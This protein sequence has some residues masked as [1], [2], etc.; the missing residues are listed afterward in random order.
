MNLFAP[1]IQFGPY[2]LIP[3]LSV[4][5]FAAWFWSRAGS[6]Y[7]VL[8]RLSRLISKSGFHSK[9]LEAQWQES[10]DVERFRF[11]YHIPAYTLQDVEKLVEWAKSNDLG[12][13]QIGEIR[14][15]ID[16]R[17]P[18]FI[19]PVP[20]GFIGWERVRMVV[21]LA[22]M[23]MALPL[24]NVQSALLI[25][26][27]SR[28]LILA[29]PEGIRPLSP[30]KNWIVNQEVCAAGVAE[31]KLV[32]G[33]TDSEAASLCQLIA[34]KDFSDFVRYTV[35]EQLIGAAVIEFPT[36]LWGFLTQRRLL[37]ATRAKALR[38]RLSK[39]AAASPA[40]AAPEAPP[41][42]EQPAARG[43]QRKKPIPEASGTSDA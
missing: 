16:V 42:A 1:L 41:P 20:K 37:S 7:I 35:R 17:T 12:M 21:C 34:R 14:S 4:L 26:N 5:L 15:W 32:S 43:R 33:F 11:I 24:I 27:H 2:K 10:H 36:I 39:G 28:Q 25:T 3:I 22:A 6:I 13:Q 18:D 29:G 9:K 38:E 23:L 30:L 40:P 8:E 31:V 19:K